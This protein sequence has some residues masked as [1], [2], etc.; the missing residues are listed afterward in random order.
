MQDDT[1]SV[2]MAGGEVFGPAL[3]KPIVKGCKILSEKSRTNLLGITFSHVG[4]NLT[5]VNAIPFPDLQIGGEFEHMSMDFCIENKQLIETLQI[6]ARK[7][8]LAEI[9]GMYMRLRDDDFLPEMENEPQ[10][11]EKRVRC[12][13]L[14]E[15]FFFFSEIA[16]CKVINRMSAMGSNSSKPFQAQIIRKHGFSIPETL[17]TNDKEAVIDFKN[18]F[19]KL[20]YKSISGIRSIVQVLGDEDVDRLKL[21]LMCP[22]QFHVRVHVIGDDVFATSI[23]T[24]FIDYRYATKFGSDA[25]LRPFTLDDDISNKCVKLSKSLGRIDLKVTPDHEVFCFEVNPSPAFSYYESNTNQPIA[26]SMAE[27]LTNTNRV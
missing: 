6:R 11:S 12:K 13:L 20:I 27:Y 17:I 24:D 22:V 23:E 15:S 9:K 25:K 5:F 21:I 2:V 16:P 10:G 4:G 3:P 1:L 26:R 7:Y 18:K 19:K 8:D 14:H